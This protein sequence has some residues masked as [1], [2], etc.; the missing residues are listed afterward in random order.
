MKSLVALIAL[1]VLSIPCAAQSTGESVLSAIGDRLDSERQFK[2]EHR[3]DGMHLIDLTSGKEI[4]VVRES[5][6]QSVVISGVVASINTLPADVRRELGERIALFNFSSRVGTLSL[7]EATGELTMAHALNPRA[8]P[9]PAMARVASIF[10]DVV[11]QEGR[12]FIR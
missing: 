4:A 3:A 6:P 1:L 5:T 10:G 12:V 9:V 11:R 7:D 2:I 8:V